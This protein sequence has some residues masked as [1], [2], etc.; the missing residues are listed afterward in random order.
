[1]SNIKITNIILDMDGTLLDYVPPC[2][3]HNKSYTQIPI[4]RPYLKLFMKYLFANFERVS[5]WT[6]AAKNWY[7]MCYETVLKEA[8]P[9]GKD[10]HFV[11]TRLN[12]EFRKGVKP[13]KLIYE[14]Y[15][16][17]Y[18]PENTLIID[19]YKSH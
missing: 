13:L 2:F 15:Q 1:M 4:A 8:L 19:E 16:D 5:I 12:Y 7:D 17:L 3:D 10:F 9:E 11:K 18:N 6:A 14:E